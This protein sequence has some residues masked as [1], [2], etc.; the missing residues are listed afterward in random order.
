MKRAPAA[1]THVTI[2]NGSAADAGR[3][4]SLIRGLAIH[5]GHL[6]NFRLTRLR[7]KGMLAEKQRRVFCLLAMRGKQTVGLLVWFYAFGSL[8]GS[9]IIF[10]ED[11]FVIPEYRG[12]GIGK[13][14]L[15]EVA[16]RAVSEDCSAVVWA[17][18]KSN[19]EAI[20]FYRS[21]SAFQN[22]DSHQFVLRGEA[23]ERLAKESA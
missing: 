8:R 20:R 2:R 23:L 5:E 11:L 7:L 9:W 6:E 19:R 3:I 14:L 13:R 4:F 16:R 17:V 18:G 10:V 1:A 22:K 12:R 15:G 21:L